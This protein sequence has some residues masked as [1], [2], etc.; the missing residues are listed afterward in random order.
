[1][2]QR[3]LSSI[4]DFGGAVK[5]S[6]TRRGGGGGGGGGAGGGSAAFVGRRRQ[7]R[8]GKQTFGN[9]F[10]CLCCWQLPAAGFCVFPATADGCTGTFPF[11]FHSYS[12]P[13]PH[14]L[15]IPVPVP[16]PFP[17]PSPSQFPFPSPSPFLIPI[18]IPSPSH[19][20]P[21]P[22]LFPIPISIPITISHPHFPFPSRSHSIPIPIPISHS[23]PHFPSPSSFL[24]PFP[25]PIPIPIPISHSH[26]HFPSH[27]CPQVLAS[28][29]SRVGFSR[30]LLLG[31]GFFPA[32]FYK[33]QPQNNPGFP[34][35][36]CVGSGGGAG[37]AGGRTKPSAGAGT[38]RD[39]GD[40]GAVLA[41]GNVPVPGTP[42][43][44]PCPQSGFGDPPPQLC[45]LL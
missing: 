16:I 3:A 10:P 45:P 29:G 5:V 8:F 44:A 34:W 14:F 6:R 20:Y 4:P 27:P 41:L 15:P 33:E 17:S 28:Q 13:H 35:F 2:L 22:I 9:L 11:P 23:H 1:M 21:V 30:Q 24:S 18:S 43:G 40:T 19:S 31:V 26:P 42:Q 39:S 12:H 38:R 25:I 7:L 37:A 32:P 36:V